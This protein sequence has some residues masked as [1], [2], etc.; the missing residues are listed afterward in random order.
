MHNI[1]ELIDIIQENIFKYN[2]NNISKNIS[3]LV[4]NIVS[5]I[6][7]FEVE[8]T[9]LNEILN[10]VNISLVNKDYLLLADILEYEFKPLIY[11]CGGENG[12]LQ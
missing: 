12:N 5:Y 3:L 10:W 2:I 7:V 1:I 6:N 11:K 9:K 8:E 4:E